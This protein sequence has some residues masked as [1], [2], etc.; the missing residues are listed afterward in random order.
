M[1][2]PSVDGIV[3]C[4]DAMAAF[5][6]MSIDEVHSWQ[7]QFRTEFVYRSDGDASSG[8]GGASPC[9]SAT[10]PNGM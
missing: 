3:A 10:P 6:S 4:V 1:R 8:A 5:R 2:G 7:L 9:V